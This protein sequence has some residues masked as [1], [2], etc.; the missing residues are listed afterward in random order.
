M[1]AAMSSRKFPDMW[2]DPEDDPRETEAVSRGEKAV[3]QEYLDRYRKT[4]SAL[5]LRK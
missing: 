5:N 1:L 4:V 2:V 3:L